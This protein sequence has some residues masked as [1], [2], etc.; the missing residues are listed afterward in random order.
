MTAITIKDVAKRADVSISTV[1]NVLNGTKY[2]D[3]ELVKRVKIAV[4]ELNYQADPI[5]RNMRTKYTKTIGV[6]AADICG[7]FYPYV[8]KGVYSVAMEQGYNVT[9]F[10][11]GTARDAT[12]SAYAKEIEAFGIFAGNRVDGVI[13]G[14]MVPEEVEQAYIN[15]VKGI[16]HSKREIVLTSIERD[17]SHV[18]IDSIFADSFEG[19]MK[20]TNYLIGLNCKRIGHITGPLEYK[21]IQDRLRGYKVAMEEAGLYMDDSTMVA[22]GDYTHQSGYFAMKKLL[23]S[24]PDIDSVFVANDQMAIGACKALS[25]YE[26]NIPLDVKVIGYDDVFV[27]SVIEPSLSTI[28]VNKYRLGVEATKALINRIQRGSQSET[29]RMELETRL[30]VRKSTETDVSPD[31]ILSEW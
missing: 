4:K 14:S 7:L 23:S 6:I 25:E 12:L 20:A 5:A 13:F 31:W 30:V 9:V 1:S 8:L 15:E 3:D 16:V 10:D 18:G 28:H 24:M 17:F 19:A 22:S 2:V 11:T 29:L 21:N 27:S 26:K